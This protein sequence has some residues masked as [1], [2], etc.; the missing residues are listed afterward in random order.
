MSYDKQNDRFHIPSLHRES[1]YQPY[2]EDIEKFVY[3][4]L[5]DDILFL[6]VLI[7][8]VH[9]NRGPPSKFEKNI[10]STVCNLK[11]KY[12][13]KKKIKQKQYVQNILQKCKNDVKKKYF[14]GTLF[15][16]A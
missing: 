15:N 9:K 7:G 1:G 6:S 12:F 2:M 5:E 10:V 4:Y 13:T 16:D 8:R 11:D 3:Q 14:R